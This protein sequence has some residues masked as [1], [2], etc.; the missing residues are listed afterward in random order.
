MEK[1]SKKEARKRPEKDIYYL[2]IA[3]QIAK[4]ATCLRRRFGA[5]IVKDDAIVA[6]GYNGAP[7]KMP[8]CID[9]DKCPRELLGI[10]QGE[11]YELC[12]GVHAE[13]NAI[14]NAA[15]VGANVLD[16]IMYV[17]GEDNNGKVVSGRPCKM[18]RRLIINAGIKEVVVPWEGKA[19]RYKVENWIK[20]AKKDPFLELKEKGY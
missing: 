16:G 9:L 2:S 1:I 7:R 11:R 8:N 15:R 10:S 3:R 13:A 12:R 4:R 20:E 14:I 6:S 5:I 18:C 19:K 17:F